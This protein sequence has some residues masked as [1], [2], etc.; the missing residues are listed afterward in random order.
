MADT[1]KNLAIVDAHPTRPSVGSY[2][3]Y[4]LS[5]DDVQYLQSSVGE[6]PMS[7]TVAGGYEVD[8]LTYTDTANEI[9]GPLTSTPSELP[10]VNLNIMTGV[11]QEY[12]MDYTVRQVTGGSVPGYYV[13]ISPTS[14][15]PGG[16][17]F[18][19]G[20]NPGSGIQNVLSNGDKV[21]VS[22]PT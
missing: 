17:S 20:S 3:I 7:S 12:I 16:G 14:T 4:V 19:G 13:C 9:I 1:Y 21:R 22:Y 18:L 5:T 11:Q 6:Y 2:H 10:S 15:A 8:Q